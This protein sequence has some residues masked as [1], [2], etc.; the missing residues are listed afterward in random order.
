MHGGLLPI[1]STQASLTRSADFT[2]V[3]ST[4]VRP[5]R[6]PTVSQLIAELDIEKCTS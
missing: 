4:T 5:F 1:A 6:V 2:A 3:L